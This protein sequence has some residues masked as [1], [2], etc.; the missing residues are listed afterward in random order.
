MKRATV[1]W[2]DAHGS[3]ERHLSDGELE[4]FHKAV[5]CATTGWVLRD[6][7]VGVTLAFEVFLPG[8]PRNE[9]LDTYPHRG[10]HFVPRAMIDSME[11]LGGE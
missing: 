2:N 8:H 9:G 11:Y 10:Y 7:D 1:W 6:D 4:A 3:S 5:Y